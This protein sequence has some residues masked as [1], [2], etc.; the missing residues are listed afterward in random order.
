[1]ARS[2]TPR[3]GKQWESLAATI[4]GFTANATVGGG[5]LDSTTSQTILRM[6]GEY[7]IS[8]TAV[9]I[10]GDQ[11]RLTMAIGIV[12]IDAK[13]L[14]ATALPDP[15]DEPDY[16]WLYYADHGFNF[17]AATSGTAGEGA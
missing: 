13:D 17:G 16:P 3:M 4:F 15:G 9:I 6:I 5:A 12:S 14:G 8:P 11:A 2:N 1:M 7:V 10:A